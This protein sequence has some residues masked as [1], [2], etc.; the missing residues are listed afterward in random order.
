MDE[1]R[2]FDRLLSEALSQLDSKLDADQR[3]LL[4]QHYNLLQHWNQK[5]SLTSICRLSEVVFRHF[6]ESLAVAKVV[7]P[8]IG[9]VVDI[10]SG[11][12]FPGIP[13]AVSWP[14]CRV[15]LVESSGKK[16]TF[17]KEMARVVKNLS[18]HN[19]RF[20][21]LEEP[22]ECVTMRAVGVATVAEQIRRQAARAVVLVSAEQAT[23]VAEALALEEHREERIPWDARTV[24]LSGQIHR[25]ARST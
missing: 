1:E 3:A 14:G 18:I 12:G 17:L 2:E 20:E 16:A 8:G 24:V 5:V 10:G 25:T 11:A 21:T 15:R 7:G 4:Y 19:S 22:M 6:G 9:S 23:G 13:V